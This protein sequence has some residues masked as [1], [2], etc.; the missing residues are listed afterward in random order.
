MHGNRRL[1]RAIAAVLFLGATVA[2]F[3]TEWLAFLW[4]VMAFPAVYAGLRTVK[5]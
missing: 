4:P 3:A 1:K 5:R 2:V